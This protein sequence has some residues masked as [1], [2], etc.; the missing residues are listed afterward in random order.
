MK[1]K[2]LLATATLVTLTAGT[3]LAQA[4]APAAKRTQPAV[5]NNCHKVEPGTVRGYFDNVAFKSQSI[6]LAI[7]DAKEIVRF[8]PKALKVIDADEAK[9]PEHM[10]EVRRS[11]S[12][13]RS[14]SPRK[15]WSTTRSSRSCR[16]S[17]PAISR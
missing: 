7:D 17:A 12:R 14:R 2:I 16:T 10:R 9:A 4:P 13:G 1:T 8:D 11:T 15:T 5:C 6:Q 3:A